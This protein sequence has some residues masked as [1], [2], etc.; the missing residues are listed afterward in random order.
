MTL[1][2]GGDQSAYAL[3]LREITPYVRAMASRHARAR[4]DIDDIVQDVLL[5][6]HAVRDT[7]DAD[8]PF[9]P[10]LV[11]LARH[12]IYDWLRRHMRL[13]EREQELDASDE[14]FR[15]PAANLEARELVTRNLRIALEALPPGQRQAF[16][17]LKLKEMTLKEVSAATGLS[18]AALK[19]ATH[20][21]VMALRK[22]LSKE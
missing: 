8:R 16:E 2:Q 3:L 1:S 7:Y 10:W 20:R 13:S 4:E 17:M 18:V 14:T 22:A 6:I 9:K 19:V 12:R 5:T 15:A 11:A 21:A